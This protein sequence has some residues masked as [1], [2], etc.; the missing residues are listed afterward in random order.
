MALLFM[1]GFDWVD[2]ALTSTALQDQIKTYWFD[3]NTSFFNPQ[4]VVSTGRLGTGNAIQLG[5]QSGSQFLVSPLLDPVVGEAVIGFA[6]RP[7]AFQDNTTFFQVRSGGVATLV[8]RVDAVGVIEIYEANSFRVTTTAVMTANEWNYIEVKFT[9]GTSGSVEIRINGT[10]Q[11]VNTNINIDNGQTSWN[12]FVI[13]CMTLG[14]STE[15]DDIYVLDTTGATNN[16]FLGLVNVK[17]LVP[18]ASGSTNTF[19]A[20]DASPAADHW[21]LVDELPGDDDLTYL[22]GSVSGERELFSYEPSSPIGAVYAVQHLVATRVTDNTARDIRFTTEFGATISD[23]GTETIASSTYKFSSI[24]YDVNPD[25]GSV[26]TEASIDA[27]DFGIT[28]D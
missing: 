21:M 17:T 14:G 19:V 15:Y 4:G 9:L 27:T 18:D 2:P 13:G 25:N 7:S 12:N 28:I 26:W 5:G 1:E 16:D 10:T 22:E 3:A 23:N 6:M 24:T 8:F 20:S 11:Y